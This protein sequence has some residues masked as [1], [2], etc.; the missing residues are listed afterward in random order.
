MIKLFF[1][2]CFFSSGI[3][4]QPK[5]TIITS[6]YKADEFIE[7]FLKEI[8]KQTFYKNCQHL[9]INANSP[10]HE[11]RH[12]LNHRAKHPNVEYLRLKFDP[13]LYAVWNIGLLKAEAD[14][15]MTANVDDQLAYAV[16]ENLYHYLQDNP[17]V[18]LVY[19]D[20]YFTHEKNSTFSSCADKTL[21]QRLEF[22]KENLKQDCSPGPHPLWRKSLHE[23]YGMFDQFFKILGDLEM[24]LRAAYH[25]AIFKRYP[26]PVS[27]FYE[28]LTTLSHNASK[29][30]L[31]K[32]EA[33]MIAKLYRL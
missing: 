16:I 17:D 22:S 7:H 11:E 18:D 26:M 14:C 19:G 25:G 12:I 10:G 29:L 27:L 8:S 6:V 3:F 4:A 2:L 13:G 23:K 21:Y 24:W 15:I 32:Q 5:V 1:A 20:L 31:R 9:I 30:K 28:G 33:R